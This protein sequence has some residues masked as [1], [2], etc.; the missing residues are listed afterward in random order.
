MEGH[1]IYLGR[2]FQ[3]PMVPEDQVGRR[4]VHGEPVYDFCPHCG[5]VETVF[6]DEEF[7]DDWDDGTP[8]ACDACGHRWG[9]VRAWKS[10][11]EGIMAPLERARGLR[12]RA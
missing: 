5:G 11:L 7:G 3:A 10:E 6:V 1:M 4:D 9:T 2:E 8:V 12:P